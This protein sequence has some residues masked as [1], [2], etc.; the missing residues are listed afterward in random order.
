MARILI[1]D[2]HFEA[3]NYIQTQY[4]Y[5]AYLELYPSDDRKDYVLFKIGESLYKQL[6]K[7]HDRDLSSAKEA[8]NIFSN[9]LAEFPDSIYKKKLLNTKLK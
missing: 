5:Q 8:I 7:V 3:K 4:T 1:A 9:M 6:L 2:I